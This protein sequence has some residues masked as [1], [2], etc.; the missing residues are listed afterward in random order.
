[1]SGAESSSSRHSTLALSGGR[2]GTETAQ[3]SESGQ[4]EMGQEKHQQ[5]STLLMLQQ[6]SVF[7]PFFSPD[8]SETNYVSSILSDRTLFGTSLQTLRKGVERLDDELKDQ[9][10][11]HR[12]SLLE[13]VGLLN[14]LH[15]ELSTL[16]TN[17]DTLA[18]SVSNIKHLL[19]EPIAQMERVRIFFCT[20]T[21]AFVFL[22][23]I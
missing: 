21:V 16:E 11:I 8:F 7:A 23:L 12:E 6:E 13:Q 15:S 17:L 3:A 20:K 10:V 2:G 5:Q 22:R 18:S 9:V 14:G 1:M 19:V 4:V